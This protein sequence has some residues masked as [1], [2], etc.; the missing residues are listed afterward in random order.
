MIG[1]VTSAGRRM[2]R[3]WKAE[4]PGKLLGR[5]SYLFCPEHCG[6]VDKTGLVADVPQLVDFSTLPPTT[7]QLRMEDALRRM[8]W[9]GTSVLHVG[10]GDSGFARRFGPSLERVVGLTISDGELAH[11]RTVAVPNYVVHKVSKY[12]W[13]F[14]P[15]MGETFDFILDNNPNSFACCKCHF[16]QML[17]TYCALLKPGGMLLTD[18]G[19]MDWVARDRRWRLSFRDLQWLERLFPLQARRVS[20]TV[21]ALVRTG[22]A[23]AMLVG[24]RCMASAAVLEAV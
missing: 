13:D 24:A 3:V 6:R 8:A 22:T 11:A 20:S 9:Q 16:H 14:R 5:P 12:S 19:G 18:Q 2:V 15:A 17:E 1:R 23:S 21:Y 10:V 4:L 7:D